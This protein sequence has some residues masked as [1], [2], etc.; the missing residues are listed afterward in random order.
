MRECSGLL[1]WGHW[2]LRGQA[3]RV[4]S[5]FTRKEFANGLRQAHLESTPLFGFFFYG[6]VFGGEGAGLRIGGALGL[7]PSRLLDEPQTVTSFPPE[8][9]NT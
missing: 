9:E 3:L 6:F 5:V 4:C 8:A 7:I 2:G 1:V